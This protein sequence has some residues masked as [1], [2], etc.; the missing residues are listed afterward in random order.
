MN[1]TFAPIHLSDTLV[2]MPTRTRRHDLAA[3]P[4]NSDND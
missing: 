1:T 4:A 2:G 3:V